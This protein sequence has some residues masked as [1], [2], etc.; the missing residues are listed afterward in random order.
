MRDID[1]E[2]NDLLLD[3]FLHEIGTA[4]AETQMHRK[5]TVSSDDGRPDARQFTVK[6]C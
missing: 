3:T 6:I 2:E 1:G 4:F 5:C